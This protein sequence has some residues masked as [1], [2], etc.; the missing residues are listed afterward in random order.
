MTF[1]VQR[2]ELKC[3]GANQFRIHF[4]KEIA[5]VGQVLGLLSL[6]EI[7]PRRLTANRS[8]LRNLGLSRVSFRDLLACS[9]SAVIRM[10]VV[11]S[12]FLS[13]LLR[14]R[15]YM[16]V[17]WFAEGKMPCV[18][19]VP[20]ANKHSCRWR[21]QLKTEAPFEYCSFR[22]ET[23]NVASHYIL[24]V[25][26]SKISFLQP[27]PSPSLILCLACAACSFQTL[28]MLPGA[29]TPLNTPCPGSV[30]PIRV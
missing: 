6:F 19:T 5:A 21:N 12:P 17:P 7:K 29:Y 18:L 22:T 14:M 8:P 3:Q 28:T 2:D 9:V 30:I 20:N 24:M 25:I 27:S 15:V 23:P 10:A 1:P 16:L 11:N 4:C 13:K 26:M